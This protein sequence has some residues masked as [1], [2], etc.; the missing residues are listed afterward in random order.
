MF[1]KSTLL[2]TFIDTIDRIIQ[3]QQP[4]RPTFNIADSNTDIAALAKKCWTNDQ[5]DRPSFNEIKKFIN[6][7]KRKKYDIKK[8]FSLM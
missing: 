8:V 4:T 6:I 2:N 5:L 1:S 3:S 7:A